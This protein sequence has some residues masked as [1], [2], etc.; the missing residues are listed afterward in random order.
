MDF[1]DDAPIRPLQIIDDHT[2]PSQTL[3]NSRLFDFSSEADSVST[4]ANDDR[5]V[6]FSDSASCAHSDA[7]DDQTVPSTRSIQSNKSTAS[8]RIN[9]I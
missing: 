4:M 5:S 6:T 1:M 8:S 3:P 9:G 2:L 7:I